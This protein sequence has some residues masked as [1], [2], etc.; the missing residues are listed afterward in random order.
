VIIISKKLKWI[1]IPEISLFL[2]FSS[3][4]EKTVSVVFDS[5]SNIN[6]ETAKKKKKRRRSFISV[7]F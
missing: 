3:F 7:L 1:F 4:C 5:S 2:S 6:F